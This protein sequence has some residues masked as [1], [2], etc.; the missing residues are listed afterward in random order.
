MSK[1]EETPEQREARKARHASRIKTSLEHTKV[2]KERGNAQRAK[3]APIKEALRKQQADKAAKV[4]AD[5]AK[6]ATRIEAG[7]ASKAKAEA[8]KG[9]AGQ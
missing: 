7:K 2:A 1:I 5:K 4:Q 3:V 6:R 8:A 9:K